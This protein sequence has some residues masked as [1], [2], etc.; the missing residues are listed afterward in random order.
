MSLKATLAR[1]E[2]RF[3]ERTQRFLASPTGLSPDDLRAL[4][5]QMAVG[6]RV[7]ELFDVAGW[8]DVDAEIGRQVEAVKTALLRMEPHRLGT[9]AAAELKGKGLGLEAARGLAG[10]IVERGLAAERR[11]LDEEQARIAREWKGKRPE[12]V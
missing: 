5:E 4:R 11:L 9:R 1:L 3:H 8:E 6:R 7:A 2:A 12:R 10:K